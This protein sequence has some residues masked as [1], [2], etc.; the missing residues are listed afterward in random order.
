VADGDSGPADVAWAPLPSAGLALVLGRNGQAFRA[1]ERRQA[2][3]LARI[4]DTR[5]RELRAMRSRLAHP[6]VSR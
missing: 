6:S 5:F 4:V 1:R 3:A 2:A